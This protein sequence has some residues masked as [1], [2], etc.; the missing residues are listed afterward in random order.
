[1]TSTSG[2]FGTREAEM[3]ILVVDDHPLILEALKQV[4]RD[5]HPDIEVLEARDATQA[6]EQTRAHPDLALVLL[7]LTLP[8]THGLE[9]LGELRR[10]SPDVPVV[11]LSATEDRETVLRAI[12]DGAMGFIP[13]TAKTEVLIAALRLVFSGGVYLPPSVVAGP[14][15]AVS[16]PRPASTGMRTPREA[17]LTERQAQVLALLVQGKSNKLICRALD[18]AEGTVKIHVT[19]ILR[20]L[21][22]SNRTEALVAVSRMGLRLDAL[23]PERPA[24]VR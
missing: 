10:D 16:E 8:R 4:L 7:D 12:N 22:V 15:N 1:M 21:H 13:K 9:L 5:L 3:K 14:A 2:A 23:L 17:G 18:L 19:A 6:V 11:V 20:A 24:G